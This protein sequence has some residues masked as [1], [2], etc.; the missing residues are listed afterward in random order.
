ML[1]FEAAMD[2]LRA[3]ETIMVTHPD[4]MKKTDETRYSFSAG[5]GYRPGTLAAPAS[6]PRAGRRRT[7]R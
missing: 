4:P 6:A 3:G 2:R 5:G 1:S 7:A